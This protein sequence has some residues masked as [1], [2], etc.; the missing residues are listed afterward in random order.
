MSGFSLGDESFDFEDADEQAFEYFL[1]GGLVP[2]GSP[3]YV[4]RSADDELY[5]LLKA[6]KFCNIFNSRQ[7]GKSSLQTH[8]EAQ[9]K[10]ENICCVYLY[11]KFGMATSIESWYEKLIRDIHQKLG[12]SDRLDIQAWLVEN[13][14]DQFQCYFDNVVLNLTGDQNIIIF[15]DEID[16]V[17]SFDFDADS[18]F[19]LLRKFHQERSARPEY[20]RL[21]F[22][23]IGVAT[24]S[25][26]VKDKRLTPYNIGY[27]IELTGLERSNSD[28]LMAGFADYVSQPAWVLDE[29]FAWTGGQ[30]LLTQWVCDEVR[31]ALKHEVA[32]FGSKSEIVGW[33]EALVRRTVIRGE[34]LALFQTIR[35]RLLA[36]EQSRGARL[37]FYRRILVEGEVEADESADVRSEQVE[38]CLSGAVVRQEGKLRVFNQIYAEVFG[39]AWVE[40]RLRELRPDNYRDAV[41]AWLDSGSRDQ[42]VLLQG[43]T[44]Q[45]ANAWAKGR[46][47]GDD[48]YRFLIAS[49]NAE[50]EAKVEL[51][52]QANVD[53]QRTTQKTNQRMRLGLGVLV[54]SIVA[55]AIASVFAVNMLWAQQKAEKSTQVA[56]VRLKSTA[57]KQKFLEGRG[58]ESLLEAL[59]AAKQLKRLDQASWK[60]DNVKM[61]VVTALQQAVYSVQEHNWFS[62]G[63]PVSQAII[64]PDG[65]IIAVSSPDNSTIKLWSQHGQLLKTLKSQHER[66][67]SMTFSPDGQIFASAGQ[68]PSMIDQ[69]TGKQVDYHGD[70]KLWNRDGQILT[71][72]NHY[73]SQVAFSPDGQMIAS[74]G[75]TDGT[76]RLWSREG[77]ELKILKHSIESELT[78]VAFS[79]DGKAI[80][81][82]DSKGNIK[83]WDLNG[84]EIQTFQVIAEGHE[85]MQGL[86]FSS[87]AQNMAVA[88]SKGSG[89]WYGSELPATATASNP[90]DSNDNGN[91]RLLNQDGK[92]T[93]ILRASITSTKSG[94]INPSTIS[95]SPD[96]KTVAAGNMDGT[97]TIWNQQGQALQTINAHQGKV[98]SVMFSQNGQTLISGGE[99]GSIRFW[100]WK[101]PEPQVIGGENDPPYAISP[102]WN[103]FVIAGKERDT[104]Q[105]WNRDAQQL[106][107]INTNHNIHALKFSPDGK[108]LVSGDNNGIIKIWDREGQELKTLKTLQNEVVERILFSPDSQLFMSMSGIYRQGPDPDPTIRVWNRDGQELKK[109]RL[110]PPEFASR[111]DDKFLA[112]E[113]KNVLVRFVKQELQSVGSYPTT[114]KGVEFSP[115]NQIIVIENDD[116]IKFL[117]RDGQELQQINPSSPNQNSLDAFGF[118]PDDQFFF[119]LVSNRLSS[120]SSSKRS[121][122]QSPSEDPFK[123]K[124]TLKLW[125]RDGKN[126]LQS[127]QPTGH[128][129]SPDSQWMIVGH[130]DGTITLW[131]RGKQIL[132]T[133]KAHKNLVTCVTISP[134][135]KMFA[136]S[137]QTGVIKLWNRNG[138]EVKTLENVY[139]SPVRIHFSPDGQRFMT[140][141]QDH[142]QKP[143]K[144]WSRDGQELKTL[145]I[146][147]SV[148]FSSDSQMIVS[149]GGAGGDG[150][151]RLWSRD[152]EELQIINEP[153]FPDVEFSPDG[154]ILMAMDRDS[155]IK[156]RHLDLDALM[157]KGC[158]W[159]RDYLESNPNVSNEDRALCNLPPK[160]SPK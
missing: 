59:R 18:F 93:K 37:D 26:L 153:G 24:P 136:T 131:E 84:K 95:F 99:D 64:S 27:G 31:K 126:I 132:K 82:S 104:I 13:S 88:I 44:L 102:D 110:A 87:G 75:I 55:A 149:T 51:T 154:K 54:T 74:A 156:L 141:A 49:N 139:K 68:L 70:I 146:Q 80:S 113:Q 145:G 143:I 96:G 36:D 122:R 130:E 109:F 47:L 50:L 16:V 155:A 19:G 38:V 32:D 107:T 63:A 147:S 119:T 52:E 41:K 103:L 67:I 28:V 29:V 83:K 23:L 72:L 71:T 2:L 118:S 148:S 105:F 85:S 33:V 1:E 57:A 100:S 78:S 34:N 134:D 86:T 9:L 42:A 125:S 6:G 56:E 159:I 112:V 133:L 62:N 46:R 108:I 3:S 144:L 22:V 10:A 21:T 117:S 123:L 48:D 121:F 15:I 77:R 8:V 94:K 101:K 60:I 157:A 25:Q 106:K 135:G 58:S 151:I 152:G 97:I 12:L 81:A 7:M 65:N 142:N 61:Q 79:L 90:T 45:E 140:D 158:D 137:D 114:V 92:I 14:D 40:A 129:F 5:R 91:F 116:T 128:S 127:K 120:R 39:L 43:E 11:L 76:V 98:N 73:A 30:P 111:P 66:V 69:K 53:L 150:V 89:S 124:R 4:R 115:D 20:K 17:L 160:I 35:D 138:Q